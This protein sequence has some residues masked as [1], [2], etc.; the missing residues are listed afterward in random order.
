MPSRNADRTGIWIGSALGGVAFGEEQHAN[1]VQRGVRAVA[2][3]LATAVFGGAGASNV[4]IDLG[5]RGPSIGNA[6]SCASGAMAIGQA[7]QAIRAGTVDAALAGGAEAPLAPLTFGAF[8][9]IR[10]LS[11]RNDDPAT[12]SRPFD[13]DRDGF[14]MG[15]GSA[16]LAL[17]DR[18]AAEARGATI[19]GEVV[20]FGAST[21]AYHLTA[22]LPSGEA[23]AAAVTTALADAGLAPEAIGY[24]NAH[25]SSRSSTSW[26]RPR[27]CTW[28]SASTRRRVPVSGTK[29]LYGHALGASGAIEAAITVMALDAGC[30]P[31]TCNLVNLDPR[32]RPERPDRAVRRAPGC[33]PLDLVRLRRHERRAGVSRRLIDASSAGTILRV[34]EL[35]EIL[36]RIEELNAAGQPMA[37]ATI[38]A[39]TGSTYRHAGARLLIPAEGEPIGNISGGCLEDDVAR[40]G[41]EVMRTGEPRLASFDLTADE[42]AVWGYGL[43]CNGSFEVFVEPTD[44]ALSAADAL[45]HDRGL[46]TSVLTGPE[47]GTHRFQAD[48]PDFDM[49]RLTE[50]DGARLFQEPILPPMRLI[51]CGAGHDAIPLV[52]Q[53]AEL[54]WRVTVADVRRAL[55]TPERFPGAGDFCDADPDAAAAAMQPDARTAVVLM[56]HNYLRD[57]AYLG[58]FLGAERRTWACWDRAAARSRCSGAGQPRRWPAACAGGLD[59]GAEG[60]EEVARAIVAEI[61]AVTRARRGPDRRSS[62][63]QKAT[64]WIFTDQSSRPVLIVGVLIRRLQPD[65]TL[66]EYRWAT[67]G[68]TRPRDV[69]C[70]ARVRPRSRHDPSRCE[71]SG[72]DAL[73]LRGGCARQTG[74]RL[75]R[76]ESST[77]L[78]ERTPTALRPGGRAA[79][80]G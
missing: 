49:P 50:E 7:F 71:G 68:S 9:M 22:P 24:V 28:R 20:G 15:E 52:R 17:E 34:S 38:V 41:R 57:I 5:I 76:V 78:R 4:S 80:H 43:G 79:I 59:I 30:L 51:V 65:P 11:S 60:P 63:A 32:L 2:P 45:R 13:V 61:L 16:V 74:A 46:L 12:A 72:D 3:T 69:T 6:N 19:L 26:R 1:Y 77:S 14:V 40:I 48:A 18:D 10:V 54:G 56:S 67:R 53:A 64:P 42:D 23:A 8:A 47:A 44:G 58:S 21:D 75:H 31:G 37:L 25:A 73:R 27:R 66:G 36:A 29:G 35:Q 55:L 39:T 62:S 33:R 70:G